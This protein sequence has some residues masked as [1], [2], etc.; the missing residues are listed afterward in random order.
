LAQHLLLALKQYLEATW[1]HWNDDWTGQHIRLTLR[2]VHDI[3][4]PQPFINK[5]GELLKVLGHLSEFDEE[6]VAYQ[7]SANLGQ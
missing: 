7:L 4:Q 3:S 1:L 5:G 6:M 2:T